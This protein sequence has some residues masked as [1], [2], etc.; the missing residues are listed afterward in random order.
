MRIKEITYDAIVFDNG[1]T[2]TYDHWQECCEENYADFKQL[3][4]LARSYD[5]DEDE[6]RFEKCESG[7]RFGDDKRMFFV[8]CYSVQ[9]GFYTN[10]VDIYYTG[11][12]K[13][14][15]DIDAE[16]VCE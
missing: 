11:R 15:D 4:D 8:P 2:I 10:E 9:N 16:Y 7:F 13:V 5:F 6:I 3:D 12:L 1:N 14:L